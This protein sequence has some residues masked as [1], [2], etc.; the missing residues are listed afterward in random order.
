MTRRSSTP[1]PGKNADD[2]SPLAVA[3]FLAAPEQ[4][5]ASLRGASIDQL[6]AK[7]KGEGVSD[8]V[9]RMARVA[10]RPFPGSSLELLELSL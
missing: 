2:L 3:S 7:L 1:I 9:I 4:V 6:V 5:D 8:D 10:V